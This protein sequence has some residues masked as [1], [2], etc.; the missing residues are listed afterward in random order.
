MNSNSDNRNNNDNS[1]N[2]KNTDT[3]NKESL[4]TT[5]S[6]FKSILY[7]LITLFIVLFLGIAILYGCKVS[8]SNILPTDN[9]CFPYESISDFG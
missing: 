2:E 7:K 5:L 1:L 4:D 9:K 3:K 6:F 8:Q